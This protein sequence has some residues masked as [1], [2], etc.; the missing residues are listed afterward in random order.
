MENYAKVRGSEEESQLPFHDLP[1]NVVEMRVKEGSKI[2]NLMG[3]AIGRMELLATR[4]IVFTGS[5]RAVTKTITCVEI[6]KRR[7]GGLHQITRLRYK[8]LRE[9]WRRQ[10][11]QDA[12]GADAAAH[13]FTLL[14]N[15]PS[16]CILLSKEPLDPSDSGY[17]APD[18]GHGLWP[19]H[20]DGQGG[21]EGSTSA[22]RGTKR[23]LCCGQGHEMVAKV[24]REEHP[25]DPACNYTDPR[26][27]QQ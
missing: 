23:P 3:F 19:G 26:N 8:S 20:R 18:S 5:G 22:A 7:I 1:L 24:T 25:M 9:T 15:V 21:E 10:Q 4:Q 2:R 14:K 16:I 11:L 17:Q 13:N 27:C 6:M 12:E